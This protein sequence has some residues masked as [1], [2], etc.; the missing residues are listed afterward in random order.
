MRKYLQLLRVTLLLMIQL[1]LQVENPT[2]NSILLGLWR[3]RGQ[4]ELV[5]IFYSH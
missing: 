1:T 4:A 5:G 2:L 3:L